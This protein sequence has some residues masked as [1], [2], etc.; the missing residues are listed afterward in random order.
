M[1]TIRYLE[2]IEQI[3]RLIRTGKTGTPEQLSKV[4]GTSEWVLYDTLRIMKQLG[5]EIEFNKDK[6][7]YVYSRKG[8][9]YLRFDESSKLAAPKKAAA[10]NKKASSGKKSAGGKKVAAKKK[11]A[12]KKSAP[13]KKKSAGRSKAKGR[14]R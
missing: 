7:K 1:S 4:L 5:A 3:D 13:V 8:G 11:S 12:A 10:N 6:Q 9:F 2:R 14:R